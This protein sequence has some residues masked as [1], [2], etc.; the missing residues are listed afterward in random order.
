MLH[1]CGRRMDTDCLVGPPLCEP[2]IGQLVL[3]ALD[4]VLNPA[5]RTIT[6]NP[7]YPN[8]PHLKMK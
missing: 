4:L 7:E 2:I 1:V 6:V 5:K 8:I 3:E